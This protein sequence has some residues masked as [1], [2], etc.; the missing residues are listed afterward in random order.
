MQTEQVYMK[1]IWIAALNV[2]SV[3]N[4][5]GR[6]GFDRLRPGRWAFDKAGPARLST[7]FLVKN[8]GRP[9]GFRAG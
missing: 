5:P 8:L 9:T 4:R 1:I 3:R 7:G 2:H 6:A